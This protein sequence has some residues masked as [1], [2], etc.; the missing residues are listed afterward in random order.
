MTTSTDRNLPW[1][2]LT[3]GI[4]FTDG[5][6]RSSIGNNINY[7]NSNNNSSS[8]NTNNNKNNNTYMSKTLTV[9]PPISMV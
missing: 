5:K 8:N 6:R 2:D 9:P 4:F 7:N 1:R 3:P